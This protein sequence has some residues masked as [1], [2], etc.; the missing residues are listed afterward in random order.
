LVN[1]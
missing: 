1:F